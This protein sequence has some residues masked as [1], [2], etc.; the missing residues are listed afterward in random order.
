MCNIGDIITVMGKNPQM[1][2]LFSSCT[3]NVDGTVEDLIAEVKK[4]IEQYGA[5]R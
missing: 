3:W 1:M 5:L 2:E 4:C